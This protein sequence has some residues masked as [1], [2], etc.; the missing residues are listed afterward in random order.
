M[1]KEV[2]WSNILQLNNE[3]SKLFHEYCK[4]ISDHSIDP[5]KRTELMSRIWSEAVEDTHLADC[6][7]L[8]D[9]FMDSEPLESNINKRAH[10]SEYLLEEVENLIIKSGR[11]KILEEQHKLALNDKYDFFQPH[12][13]NSR[14]PPMKATIGLEAI[15]RVKETTSEFVTEVV[16]HLF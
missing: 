12:T 3:Q 8:V 6:L 16:N 14:K 4:L 9:Y 15:N 10:I 1:F 2:L 13:E 5:E 7:E 11:G